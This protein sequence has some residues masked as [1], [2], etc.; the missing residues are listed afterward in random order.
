M[1]GRLTTTASICAAT[2]LALAL[3]SPLTPANA[4]SA[5]DYLGGGTGGSGILPLK[6]PSVSRGG[7]AAP[8]P[9]ALPGAQSKQDRVT[10]S[11]NPNAA[12]SPN[13][14][15]F[16]AINRGDIADARDAINRGAELDAR[17]VLGLTPMDLSIDL[18]RNDITMLL[19]SMRGTTSTARSGKPSA[20]GAAADAKQAKA[21]PGVRPPL[22]H[23]ASAKSPAAEP[24]VQRQF[25]ST[26][27]G[28][29]AP[30]VG[31]LGFGGTPRP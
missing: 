13:D 15:L 4:Q 30:Q 22:P 7:P 26:D 14:G 24:L 29:P 19:L 11:S 18:S 5:G 20:H 6:T 2:M 21:T 12:M 27:P 16:D 23:V 17:N 9:A 31:F 1:S 28:T 3:A 10:P 25:V 8:L